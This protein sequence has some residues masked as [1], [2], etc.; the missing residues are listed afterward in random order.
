MSGAHHGNPATALFLCP[1]IASSAARRS[2]LRGDP[3][4]REMAESHLRGI[5]TAHQHFLSFCSAKESIAALVE[6]IFPPH[7]RLR[8]ATVCAL[9]GDPLS[10]FRLREDDACCY[11]CDALG[12]TEFAKKAAGRAC[13]DFFYGSSLKALV[14]GEPLWSL[15][16]VHNPSG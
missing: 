1:L 14:V 16:T 3:A 10:A 2:P 15:L 13:T 9:A 6:H 5:L 12:E 7:H 11:A 4:V 8:V